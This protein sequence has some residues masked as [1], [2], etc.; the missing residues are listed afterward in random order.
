MNTAEKDL[1][2]SWPQLP[3][4]LIPLVMDYAMFKP[5]VVKIPYMYMVHLGGNLVIGD[6]ERRRLF[7]YD[8]VS[9][10]SITGQH[11]GVMSVDGDIISSGD[12]SQSHRVRKWEIDDNTTIDDILEPI[13][14]V[15]ASFYSAELTV[16][17]DG[18]QFLRPS[19]S[20]KQLATNL[21]VE[22]QRNDVLWSLT[23][24]KRVYDCGC[25][26]VYITGAMLT[27]KDFNILISNENINTKYLRPTQGTGIRYIT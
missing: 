8:F 14:P 13:K 26:G 16:C 9:G 23:I 25:C 19:I 18:W 12:M 5:R 3:M 11:Y 1:Y 27:I 15:V 2:D 10:K 4:E 7:L 6:D 17:A 20:I 22:Y 21:L 24:N